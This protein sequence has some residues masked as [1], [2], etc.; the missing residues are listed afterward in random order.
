MIDHIGQKQEFVGQKKLIQHDFGH[1]EKFDTTIRFL[2]K[3]QPWYQVPQKIPDKE[4]PQKIEDT[5]KLMTQQLESMMAAQMVEKKQRGRSS[6]DNSS[7]HSRRSKRKK[8]KST[9]RIGGKSKKSPGTKGNLVIFESNPTKQ[10]LNG[11]Q[12]LEDDFTVGANSLG[13]TSKIASFKK[14]GKSGK[15]SLEKYDSKE[16]S[17]QSPSGPDFDLKKIKSPPNIKVKRMGRDSE[18]QMT[19]NAY[20]DKS[21]C[22]NSL[23][24]KTESISSKSNRPGIQ[25]KLSKTMKNSAKH[26]DEEEKKK[27]ERRMT[28]EQNLVANPA[29]SAAKNETI[30]TSGND[31]PNVPTSIQ[32]GSSYRSVS[33][34]IS[35]ADVE[36]KNANDYHQS[37]VKVKDLNINKI[38]SQIQDIKKPDNKPVINSIAEETFEINSDTRSVNR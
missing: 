3:N 30:N 35:Q 5:M 18:I 31:T 9:S 29:L 15:S 16:N 14:T 20:N 36:D 2:H 26:S 28:I 7:D 32:K 19:E 12:T 10:S 6:M 22:S 27:R 11:A 37:L 38:K 17:E 8:H 23:S 34:S 13:K 1:K 21:G 24:S 33:V 4:L 25:R